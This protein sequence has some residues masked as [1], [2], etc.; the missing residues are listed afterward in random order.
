M[1][2]L[3]RF[4]PSI[5]SRFFSEILLI[6]FILLGTLGIIHHAMWRDE[7]QAWMITQHSHSLF[8]LYANL[9][10]ESHPPL[11]YWLLALIQRFS[12]NPFS[13]QVLHLMIATLNAW[14]LLK[15]SPFSKMQR[16]LLVFGF[17]FFYE[18]A[19][20]SRNYALGILFVF[21]FCILVRLP[22]RNYIFLTLVLM[23]LSLS[24]I[25][26]LILAFAFVAFLVFEFFENYSR[27]DLYQISLCV[28]VLGITFW[29]SWHWMMPNPHDG[30]IKDLMRLHN[31][32]KFLH[33][34]LHVYVPCRLMH[35]IHSYFLQAFSLILFISSFVLFENKKSV[36]L[37]YVTGA[38]G[39]LLFFSVVDTGSFRHMGHLYIL[40]IACCWICSNPVC[41]AK[42]FMLFVLLIQFIL[43]GYAYVDNWYNVLSDGKEAA[44]YIKTHNLDSLPIMGDREGSI[45]VGGYLR[46]PLFFTKDGQWRNFFIYDNKPFP[47]QVETLKQAKL[48]SQKTKKD[49]VMVLNHGIRWKEIP[50]PLLAP[51]RK[52]AYFTRAIERGE[53]DY[54]YLYKYEP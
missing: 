16:F 47:S 18:Y 15:Y 51:V 27:R 43:G 52:L 4:I 42:E 14:L 40:L 11:W 10:Y 8:D 1:T 25:F 53:I 19:L 2:N 12:L 28:L 41:W 50:R 34:L 49:V 23:L 36:L 22:R 54:I 13:M 9:K 30:Y 46:K 39:M 7:L 32:N 44:Q 17:Y 38:M 37:L 21:L 5:F 24:S 3:L 31:P 35:G 33:S 29:F 6:V 20:V 26:G 48:L 45:T